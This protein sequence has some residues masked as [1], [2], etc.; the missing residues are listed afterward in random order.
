MAQAPRAA[1]AVP[2]RSCRQP[3]AAQGAARGLPP[4]RRRRDVGAEAFADIQDAAHPR[5]RAAAGGGRA[6]GRH[7]R[8]VPPQLLLGPVRRALRAASPSSPRCSSSATTTATR[9]TSPPP[10]P[11]AKLARTQ[12]LA[13]DEFAFLRERHQGD[14]E[15]HHAG[16]LDHAFLPLHRFRRPEPSMPT[17]SAFFADLAAHLSRGDRRARQGRLPLHP[18]RRGGGRHAVRPGHPR[19]DRRR[20]PGPRRAGRSLHRRHQRL[21]RRRAGRHGDR[22]AHVPRQ[23]PRPLSLGGRLRV[24]GRALLRQQPR[25]RTSC[26]STTR[27]APATSSRCASCPKD[28]GVVLGLVSTKTPVLE[29]LDDLKRRIDE[30]AKFIDLGQARH[31]PAVRL[32]LHRRRQSPDR[33]RR[34]RQ[35]RA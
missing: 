21:R 22:R 34:A 15:D 27:R 3:A 18:A 8:R 30:A 17:P 4:A 11:T 1:P 29:T 2:R 6:R 28:K 33:G 14:A 9:S 35:A 7:R 12:P 25:S 31:R 32:C 20:R 10:T 19:Q 16:A 24:G 23:L 26:S 13:A 5:R